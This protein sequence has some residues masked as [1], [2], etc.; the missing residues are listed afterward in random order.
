MSEFSSSSVVIEASADEVRAVLFDLA[1][2]PSW[3]SSFKSVGVLASDDSSRA[4]KVKIS[5]DAGV[6]RDNVILDFDWSEAPG[7]LS[8]ELDDADL[9][10]EM[11]GAFT[12]QSMG[13]ETKV[14][15]ELKV[16]L[17]MPVPSMMRQKA[18]L[19]TI[20]SALKQLKEKVEG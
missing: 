16:G 7:K 20:E 2:Y 13:D 9:L 17:S 6:L 14:T 10:T 15:Y 3:L 19:A 5:V 1:N 8:F 4:T 11:A 18:E 12:L